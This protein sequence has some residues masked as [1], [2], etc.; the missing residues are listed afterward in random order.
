M[1]VLDNGIKEIIETKR[2][3]NRDEL[4]FL[5]TYIDFYGEKRTM[6]TM[7]LE[8]AKVGTTWTE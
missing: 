1:N 2:I 4:C 5:V 6:K 7:K 8:Y 3:I